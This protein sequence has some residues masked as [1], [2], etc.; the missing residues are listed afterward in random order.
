V[1]FKDYEKQ[2]Y[3]FWEPEKGEPYISNKTQCEKNIV[4]F[5]RVYEEDD[6]KDNLS[7]SKKQEIFYKSLNAV[8]NWKTFTD[9]EL[10][11]SFSDVSLP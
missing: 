6:Y 9:D 10:C 1:D 5:L 8:D 4:R 7:Q 3:K 2:D 11:F